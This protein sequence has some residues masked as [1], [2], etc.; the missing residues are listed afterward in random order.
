MKKW[1]SC[2]SLSVVCP[3]DW[4]YENSSST[5]VLCSCHLVY[6]SVGSPYDLAASTSTTPGER[7]FSISK[8]FVTARRHRIRHFPWQ[9]VIL[10]CLVTI[11]VSSNCYILPR[12]MSRMSDSAVAIQLSQWLYHEWVRN[13]YRRSILVT[14]WITLYILRPLLF[15]V[16]MWSYYIQVESSRHGMHFVPNI[17]SVLVQE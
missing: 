7:L 17:C 16:S 3:T 9:N 10:W 5:H 14:C 12:C 4:S 11:K 2:S 1:L 15:W 13:S 8:Y 6:C